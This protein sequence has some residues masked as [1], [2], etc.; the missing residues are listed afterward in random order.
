MSEFI[1]EI[2]A[3]LNDKNICFK[4]LDPVF[5]IENRDLTLYVIP[6]EKSQEPIEQN[7]TNAIYIYEDVWRS[8]KY[9]IE[10]RMAAHLGLAK[11]IFARKCQVVELETERAAKFLAKYHSY[12]SA[13]SKFKYGLKYQDEIVAVAT[14]SAPREVE[15]EGRVFSSCEWVRYSS[16]LDL[17]VVGGM[18]KLLAAFI[19]AQKPQEIMTYAD[20]EW[21]RGDA[22]E[23][24]GFKKQGEITPIKFLI[25]KK[26]YQRI[27]EKKLLYD[28]A[29][30]SLIYDKESYYEIYNLG[31][32]KYILT[33][34]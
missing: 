21:S 32:I 1:D 30:K 5:K 26:S 20:K 27:S 2:E 25:D 4:R 17:R 22:Y 9:N 6:K 19:K 18:G 11:T 14:F 7:H 34:P 24:L 33:L 23:K 15:R 13:R 3:F 16:L 12:G 29:Y 28:N 10:R 8:Q 31:S